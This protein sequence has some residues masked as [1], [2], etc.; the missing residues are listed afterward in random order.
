MSV[1]IEDLGD[2]RKVIIEGPHITSGKLVHEKSVFDT[3][4]SRKLLEKIL[5]VKKEHFKDELERTDY[6][7]T[8]L[9]T[10]MER[11]RLDL[12]A[13]KL[14]LDYGCG[15]GASSIVLC[16]LGADNIEAIDITEDYIEIAKLR[17]RECMLNAKINFQR[18]ID[19]TKLPFENERFDIVL[20]NALIEHIPPTLRRAHLLE[21]WRVLK[22]GGKLLITETPNALWP[23]DMHTTGLWLI[24][25]LP[26][27]LARKYAIA[28]SELVQSDESLEDLL[29]RGIRGTTYFEIIRCLKGKRFTVLNRLSQE[30]MGKY[31]FLQFNRAQSGAKLSL[32]KAVKLLYYTMDFLICRPLSI[33][34]VSFFPWLTICLEKEK[35]VYN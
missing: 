18:I 19:T 23:K 4:Y 1:V 5:E 32:K 9:K 30:E 15:S 31:F 20:C 33:P 26:M 22:P 16:N 29:A 28:F 24:P 25:Y 27:K 6:I 8:H 17:A 7:Y 35:E 12:L 10:A 14:I 3:F 34:I 11:F 2:K 21:I 13:G